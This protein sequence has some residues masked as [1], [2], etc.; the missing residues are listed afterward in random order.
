MFP[1]NGAGMMSRG[2][3]AGVMSPDHGH[4]GRGQENIGSHKETLYSMMFSISIG[5]ARISVV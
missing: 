3:G 5:A 1:D 4:G 2:H